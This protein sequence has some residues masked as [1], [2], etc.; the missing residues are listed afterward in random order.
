TI[1]AEADAESRGIS[2]VP[3]PSTIALMLTGLGGL[4]GRAVRR[5]RLR[6]A[7]IIRAAVL[8]TRST[9]LGPLAAFLLLQPHAARA[10]P[11]GGQPPRCT[12]CCKCPDTYRSFAGAGSI[13]LTEGN[14]MEQY[15]V[16][17]LTSGSGTT[18]ALS[19]TYHSFNADGS[20]ANVDT[21]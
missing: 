11:Y 7:C 20:H 19:L 5:R 17:R 1:F 12:S 16:S 15:N 4:M 21:V 13:G 9:S 6:R 18:L 8:E 2:T 14:L 10:E 3:E